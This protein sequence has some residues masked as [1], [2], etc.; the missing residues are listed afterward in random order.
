[1]V[2]IIS[3]GLGVVLVG[4]MGTRAAPPDAAALVRQ[5]RERE[6]WIERVESIRVR[7]V[8]EWERTPKGIAHGRRQFERQNPGGRWQEDP[9][10]RAR[11]T[12]V[13]EQA[14][15]RRR[16]RLR[17]KDEGY[18]DDLRVWDGKLFFLQNRYADWPGLRPDQDGTLVSRDGASWLSSLVWSNFSC[19]R[20][21]LH[22]FW[23]YRPEERAEIEGW[24]PRP[25]DFAYEGTVEF[26]GFPCHVVSHWDSW[27]S[28]FIGVDDGRL[29]GIRSGALDT[30]KTK[31]SILGLLREAG[32]NVADEADLGRPSASIT[33]EELAK[34]TRLGAARMT[35]LID[36]VFEYRLSLNKEV[37]PGCRLPLVQAVR[38]FEVGDDGKAFE[39]QYN[40]L[41]IVEIKVNEPMPDDLFVVDV[42]EGERIVDPTF[43][44]TLTYRHEPK[45]SP[46]EWST[47]I[48]EARKKARR[49]PAR[50]K[51]QAALVGRAAVD[52]PAGATWL[53]GRA[54]SLESLKGKVVVLVFW[55]EW[56]GPCRGELPA[57]ADLH[58]KR[59]DDLVVIGVHPPGS[60]PE[61]V[62][63]AARDLAIEYPVCIDA[64]GR[65]SFSSSGEL[66]EAYGV[67]HVPHVVVIDRRGKIAA[68]GAVG[69]MVAKVAL[70]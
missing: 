23:W 45:R 16:I 52:F 26:H 22:A 21:G 27:T 31:R 69:D 66:H 2:W 37:A 13:I 54:I 14:Y 61:E 35:R 20:A 29:H 41:K 59:P 8:Q 7:A 3:L 48:T 47:I 58:R 50:E 12:W 51:K 55:A 39:Q 60:S 67:D 19:F 28:L 70:P 57:I 53:D 68:S 32:R 56:S 24:T 9:N 6:A 17:V 33:G 62:R 43:Q 34:M 11:C 30:A 64:P 15:D 38:F 10:L 44:P 42:P 65:Q 36:P 5:V 18:S 1:M 25:E 49:D 63:K 40:E 4:A 46:A